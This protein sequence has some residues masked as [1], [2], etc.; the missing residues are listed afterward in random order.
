MIRLTRDPDRVP[1][2]WG[3]KLGGVPYRPLGTP[4]PVARKGD[5]PLSFLAQLN[6]ADLN[7]D[8][9]HLPDFPSTGLL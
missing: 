9:L 3:S 2:Y 6:L 1:H 4:W 5:Y 7:P 8:G